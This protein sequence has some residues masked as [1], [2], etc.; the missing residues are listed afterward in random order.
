MRT[1]FVVLTLLLSA[2]LSAAEER[3]IGVLEK[4]TKTGACAQIT[5]SLN[6]VYYITKTDEEEKLVA[7]IAGKNIKVVIAGTVESRDAETAYFFTLK[8]I[9]AY[10]PK[11]PIKD[12][13]DPKTD[14]ANEPAVP[15]LIEKK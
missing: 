1:L 2:H 6:E 5:D 9:D 4:T 12:A 10:K 14:P 13:T 11:M 7:P 3:I 15:S 8:T